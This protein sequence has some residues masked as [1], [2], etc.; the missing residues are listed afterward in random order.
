MGYGIGFTQN[1]SLLTEETHL[2]STLLLLLDYQMTLIQNPTVYKLH[3]VT[4]FIRIGSDT[5]YL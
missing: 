5:G 1:A 2:K 4:N 3:L